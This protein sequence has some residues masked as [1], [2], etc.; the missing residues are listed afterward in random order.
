MCEC[1]S[2]LNPIE[3]FSGYATKN[4]EL[5]RNL[6]SNNRKGIEDMN[7]RMVVTGMIVGMFLG[8]VGCTEQDRA[9]SFGG[10]TTI[11]LPKG[12]KLVMVTWKESQIWF[13]TREM[14]EGDLVETYNFAEKSSWGILEGSVTIKEN[15]SSR[16]W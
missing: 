5:Q 11:E 15:P 3:L 12:K 7:G 4:L 16:Q 6:K 8:V 1:R 13:L 2:T 10:S 9:K 14:R